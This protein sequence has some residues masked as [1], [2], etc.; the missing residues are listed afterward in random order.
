[1]AMRAKA[2][3]LCIS[4]MLGAGLCLA[5]EAP[6]NTQPVAKANQPGFTARYCSGFVSDQKVPS[7]TYLISGEQSMHKVV[8]SQGD[9]VYI[10]RG[11]NQGVRQGDRYMVVRPE[12]DPNRVMWFKWQSKL[13]KAMGTTYADLGQLEVVNVQPKVSIAKVTFSCEYMQRG[14]IVRPFAERVAPEYKSEPFDHFAPVSGKPVAMVVEAKD[15]AQTVGANDT[16]YVNLG[17]NQGV[18]TGEYFR[19]FRYQGTMAETAPNTRDYQYKLYGFGSTP[20]VY[21]WN[22]LPREVLGE[23]IVLNASHN[24]ATVLITYSRAEIYAGDYVEIE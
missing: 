6:Q 9:Y 2:A 5:Q 16:I 13:L 12:Q 4:L 20:Q 15:F 24:S 23:G 14:D 17:T 10:N 21:Q 11:S 7:D 8:F 1:M 3:G 19:I 22:D 18:R